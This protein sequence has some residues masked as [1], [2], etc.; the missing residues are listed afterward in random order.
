M[1]SEY[2]RYPSK[3][4]PLRALYKTL[5][6]AAIMENTIPPDQRQIM[7]TVASSSPPSGRQVER[8]Y[9]ELGET[10]YE[11]PRE[12]YRSLGLLQVDL[13]E[14]DDGSQVWDLVKEGIELLRFVF[15]DTRE[16]GKAWI[17]FPFV[18]SSNDRHH[19]EPLN[20]QEFDNLILNLTW[21]IDVYEF[22]SARPLKRSTNA[23]EAVGST[24]FT[25]SFKMCL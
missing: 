8:Q 20:A 15:F 10:F 19:F 11:T 18:G 2:L 21:A 4:V 9:D 7:A 13:P 1:R 24:I 5:Q 17:R 6:A 16:H 22:L 23:G 14:K 25:M 12:Q 3:T